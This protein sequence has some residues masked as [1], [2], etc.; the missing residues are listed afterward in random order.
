M[1]R[2]VF[3]GAAISLLFIACNNQYKQTAGD[4]VE[5]VSNDSHAAAATVMLPAFNLTDAS[6]HAV[7]LQSL[8]GKKVFVNIWATWCPPCRREMPSIEKLYKSTDK[9][10]TAFA[11]LS[12]D[13]KFEKAIRYVSKQKLT[14]PV[15]YPAE[16]LPELF[17]VQAIPTTFIFN[18]SG[19][20][21]R[22][23]NGSDEYDAPEYRKL[24]Q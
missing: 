10:K 2:K 15:Y 17:N 3:I 8:K 20:L 7:N 16:N 4:A 5:Q 9:S 19:E 1:Y 21:I 22:R 23:I 14:L 13:D 18:E 6:G 11:M 24:L 12:V